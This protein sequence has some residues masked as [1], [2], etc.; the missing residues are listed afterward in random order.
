M[1]RTQLLSRVEWLWLC[2]CLMRDQAGLRGGRKPGLVSAE[3]CVCVYLCRQASKCGR[4]WSTAISR[5]G[6]AGKGYYA[7]SILVCA[8]VCVFLS[9]SLCES[10]QRPWQGIPVCTH[11]WQL[12]SHL[13]EDKADSEQQKQSVCVCECV[14]VPQCVHL[15]FSD[16]KTTRS[17]VGTTN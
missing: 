11:D 7:K 4:S 12:A 10:H 14:S 5:R 3:G 1:A 15:I 8:C 2:V 13:L 16:S 17:C 9:L 6:E